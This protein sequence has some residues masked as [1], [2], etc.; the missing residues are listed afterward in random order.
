MK[1]TQ[2]YASFYTDNQILQADKGAARLQ[3]ETFQTN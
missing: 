1:P 3:D 2:I